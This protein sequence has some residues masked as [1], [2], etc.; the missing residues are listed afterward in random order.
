VEDNIKVKSTC[1][2]ITKELILELKPQVSCGAAAFSNNLLKI[3]G[4][5]VGELGEDDNIHHD[6]AWVVEEGVVKLDV[7][8]EGIS[9]QGQ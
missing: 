2:M 5:R 9:R 8:G 4:D 6:P 7:V 1:L 3:R